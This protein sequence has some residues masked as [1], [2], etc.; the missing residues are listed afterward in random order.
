MMTQEKYV[1][2]VP[3]LRRH[4]RTIGEIAA[5]LRQVADLRRVFARCPPDFRVSPSRVMTNSPPA[6]TLGYERTGRC[7]SLVAAPAARRMVASG[8]PRASPPASHRRHVVPSHRLFGPSSR[9]GRPSSRRQ[10]LCVRPPGSRRGCGRQ[11][12]RV[13]E[14]CRRG[15]DWRGPRK[16]RSSRC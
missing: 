12:A 10:N 2:K 7:A 13:S 14:L 4:G 3:A 16:A 5:E 1:S 6:M 8:V 9:P 11:P 15:T